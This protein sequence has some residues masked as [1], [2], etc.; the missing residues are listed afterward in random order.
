MTV[1]PSTGGGEVATYGGTE[2]LDDVGAGDVV[3]PRLQIKHDEGIFIDNLSKQTFTELDCVILGLVKQRIFWADEVEEGDKPLCKSP[4]HDHGFPQI[5][6]DVKRDKR[7]PWA[8]SNFDPKDFPPDGPNAINGLVTLP[9]AAC[10][11]KEWDNNGFNQKVPPCAEQHTYPLLYNSNTEHPDEPIWAAAILTVQKTG[12][13]PSK[14]Y[15][16]SFVQAN[17][18]MFTARS[19]VSLTLNKRGTVTYSVPTFRKVGQTDSSMW[20]QYGDQYRQ[21]RAFCRTP[22][23]NTEE[24]PYVPSEGFENT[25]TPA[26][27]A[28]TNATENP[29]PAAAAPQAASPTPATTPAASPP[30]AAPAPASPEDPDGLPF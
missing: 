4:D 13:A 17:Q 2:G 28:A 12:I 7:F 9:C 19:L 3:I 20:G 16:S 22:P 5:S 6:E 27:T 26:P 14:R 11:F 25:N 1:V 15:L 24:D 21:I 23:R 18:P 30:A 8:Q 10:Q 29:S